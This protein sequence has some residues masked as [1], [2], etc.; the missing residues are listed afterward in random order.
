M[1]PVVCVTVPALV[2]SVAL[3]SV[4]MPP[5]RMSK[6][7]ALRK[8]MSPFTGVVPDASI[9]PRLR[10]PTVLPEWGRLIAFA[11][12]APRVIACRLA[13]WMLPETS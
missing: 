6:P 9:A 11:P 8:V 3:P 12:V 7:F 5:A 10:E 1:L 2:I 4:A 13:D